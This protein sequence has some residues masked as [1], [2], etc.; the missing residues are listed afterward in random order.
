MRHFDYSTLASMSWDSEIIGLVAQ[1]H[2]YK[3]RQELYF[4]D[5]GTPGSKFVP[6]DGSAE[7]VQKLYIDGVSMPR[8]TYGATGSGAQFIDDNHFS[9]TGVARVL[10]DDL[11]N[12]IVIRL[13]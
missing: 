11:D 7:R 10:R 2:E 9:G 3:G 1:I 8:G 13:K 12:P 5:H 6:L 4:W